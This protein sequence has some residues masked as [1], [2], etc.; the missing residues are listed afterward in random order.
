MNEGFP[1]SESR[2]PYMYS[3][4]AH[5]SLSLADGAFIKHTVQIISPKRL[6]NFDFVLLLPPEIVKGEFIPEDAVYF[7][8]RKL[9]YSFAH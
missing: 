6:V 4:A 8:R 9:G 1:S 2:N 7:L 5:F 3:L